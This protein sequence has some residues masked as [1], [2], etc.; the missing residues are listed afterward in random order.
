MRL[1]L[2]VAFSYLPSIRFY[3]LSYVCAVIDFISARLH[4]MINNASHALSHTFFCHLCIQTSNQVT[5]KPLPT[6][7]SSPCPLYLV[8]ASAFFIIAFSI[9]AA[10]I[11]TALITTALITAALSAF[12]LLPLLIISSISATLS[13]SASHA[14]RL[15]GGKFNRYIFS[16]LCYHS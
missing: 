7:R 4:Q 13:S 1:C 11:A 10:L 15:H 16:F 2:L 8:T 5:K 12:A 3:I 6:C 9:S 14:N